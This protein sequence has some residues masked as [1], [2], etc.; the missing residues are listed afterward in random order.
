MGGLG[1]AASRLL[2]YAAIAQIARSVWIPV[3]GG[4]GLQNWQHAVEFL[5]WGSTLVTACTQTW[6]ERGAMRWLRYLP[7]ARSLHGHQH[8]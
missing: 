1:G 6:G 2:S 3:V 8:R 4:G 5:M 7:V